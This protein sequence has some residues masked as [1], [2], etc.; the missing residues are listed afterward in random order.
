[1]GCY[2]EPD[3]VSIVCSKCKSMEVEGNTTVAKDVHLVD[4]LPKLFSMK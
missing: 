1:M 4:C 2:L 3:K